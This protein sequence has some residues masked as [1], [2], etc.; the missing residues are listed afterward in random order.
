MNW[1]Y[2]AAAVGDLVLK[3]P[4][5]LGPSLPFGTL[6]LDSAFLTIWGNE[7]SNKSYHVL[8]LSV[9]TPD[10]ESSV[11][12]SKGSSVDFIKWNNNNR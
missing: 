5:N 11:T 8:V 1:A 6:S 3:M 2:V 9:S 4:E 10:Q 12:T 7:P